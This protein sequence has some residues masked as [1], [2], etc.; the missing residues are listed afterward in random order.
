MSPHHPQTSFHPAPLW[1]GNIVTLKSAVQDTV[2]TFSNEQPFQY[3]KK[4]GS[5]YWV[6][7]DRL[8]L[9]DKN[10]SPFALTNKGTSGR[11]YLVV[12]ANWTVRMRVKVSNWKYFN[13]SDFGGD[14]KDR[15]NITVESP[16]TPTGKWKSSMTADFRGG[17]MLAVTADGDEGAWDKRGTSFDDYARERNA[18]DANGSAMLFSFTAPFEDYSTT[19][20]KNYYFGTPSGGVECQIDLLSASQ[21]DGEVDEETGIFEGDT[22][23]PTTGNVMNEDTQGE[24]IQP[25]GWSHNIL[26]DRGVDVNGRAWEVRLRLNNDEQRWYVVVDG[27]VVEAYSFADDDEGYESAV[28]L[29]RDVAESR[30]K[31]AQIEDDDDIDNANMSI[32]LGGSLIAIVAIGIIVLAVRR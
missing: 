4:S 25:S 22:I 10:E 7:D 21:N 16:L 28:A 12:K 8:V 1:G 3:T 32:A 2:N 6:D 5:T 18:R 29:G 20:T 15:F 11:L 19:E 17:S 24:Y 9:V 23:V 26:I 27:N 14:I 30:R 31:Q 13:D